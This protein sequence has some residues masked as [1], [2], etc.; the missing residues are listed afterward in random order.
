M[1]H[2]VTQISLVNGV[3]GLLINIPDATVMSIELNFRAGD[4]L[5]EHSKWETP[6]LMEHILLGA[7]KLYPKSK[8]FQ[9]ELE[10]NGAYANAS[11]GSYDITYEAECADFEWDRIL[12]LIILSITKPLFL[13]S[14]YTSELGNIKEELFSRSNNHFRHLNLALRKRYG[15]VA[16][17]DQE[18]LNLIDN[19]TLEDVKQH[20]LKT[21]YSANLRFVIAGNLTKPRQEVIE[22]ALLNIELPE[23]GYRIPLPDEEPLAQSKALY[24]N[25]SSV[26]NLYFYFDTFSKRRITDGESYAL[27]LANILLTETL[28]SRIFGQAREQGLIYGISSGYARLLGSTNFWL[29]S[30]V[31]PTNCDKLFNII[32]KEIN[33]L[34][35]G[36]ISDDELKAAKL[37]A[38]G[39]YQRGAQ[40]VTQIA[41]MYSSRY[42]YEEEYEDYFKIPEKI[43]AVTQDQLEAVF[44]V[45]FNEKIYGFGVLGSCGDDL[46]QKLYQ[47]LNFNI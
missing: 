41:N 5:V 8:D 47:S 36:K 10:K 38:L 7:N 4:F 16:L 17:T 45:L 31:M 32:N 3:K 28:H 34:L 30:Q 44:N 46:A 12:G 18:R 37:Y 39:R 26:E 42:F 20:Y 2:S 35:Q 29:G 22:K 33:N 40:T 43:Q 14:E 24:I 27:S 15:F 25:N 11:T 21:H 6:H 1:K 13:Q 23:Q 19:V 9:A